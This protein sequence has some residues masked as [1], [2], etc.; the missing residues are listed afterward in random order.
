MTF[1]HEN[2]Q[3]HVELM[4]ESFKTKQNQREKGADR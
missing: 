3:M 4:V 1:L 2:V